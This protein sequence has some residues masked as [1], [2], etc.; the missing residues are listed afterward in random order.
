MPTEP[1]F[2]LLALRT[3][4]AAAAAEHPGTWQVRT[5]A[6]PVV[7]VAVA[8][9]TPASGS[10]AVRVEPGSVLPPGGVRVCGHAL[11]NDHLTVTVDADGTLDLLGADGTRLTGVGR[12]VDGGD[13]GD[14]YNYGPP[15]HDRLVDAPTRV[16]VEVVETGPVRGGILVRRAYDWPAALADDVDHRAAQ[17][18]PVTVET[19][20]RLH[21]DEP[22]VRVTTRFTNPSADHR[23]RFHVPLPAPV[24]GSA[25]EGQF[26]VTERGLTSEGG[27]G[28]YPLPTFPASSFVTA[29]PATVLLEH[30]A[31]YEVVGDELAVTL[32]RAIGAISVNLHPLRDEPAALHLPAP[33]AQSLGR[34]VVS[35]LAILPSAH[36][37]RAAEAVRAAELFR[38][39]AAVRR[40]AAPA[41]APL[42]ASDTGIRVGG[43][44][45]AVSAVRPVAGGTEVRLVAMA[46]EPVHATVAGPFTTVDT[47]TLLGEALAREP[48]AGELAVA[49]APWEI[50]TLRL[51][52]Q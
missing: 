28:E 12:L 16:E 41:A 1:E 30:T 39:D 5:L 37:W 32:L 34:E 14:S 4:V 50:R 21:A 22:F 2:D 44:D 7:T 27:W 33:G 36:G 10:T 38:N 9:P 17:T 29:G 48:A 24:A 15:A 18:R 42:P 40:G 43:G 13:R 52:K 20:V 8:V 51:R 47:T 19:L 6:A 26:A 45:V 46:P 49:L 3:A 25:A 31:E 35:R 11:A 23:L